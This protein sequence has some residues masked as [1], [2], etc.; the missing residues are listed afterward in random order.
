MER[1][2][3]QVEQKAFEAGINPRLHPQ[4]KKMEPRLPADKTLD[5][6]ACEYNAE[7]F[8]GYI[9]TQDVVGSSPFRTH[10]DYFGF[11]VGDAVIAVARIALEAER[12][13]PGC[14][15]IQSL[16][17]MNAQG[18][19]LGI[20]GADNAW[21]QMYRAPGTRLQTEMHSRDEL[22]RFVLEHHGRNGVLVVFNIGWLV[23]AIHSRP[24]IPRCLFGSGTY[25]SAVRDVI[26]NDARDFNGFF[27]VPRRESYHRRWPAVLYK[28]D[29]SIDFY[30]SESDFVLLEVYYTA[31]IWNAI[32]YQIVADRQR[33][34]A[35]LLKNAYIIGFG[36]AINVKKVQLL[37]PRRNYF[38]KFIG[39]GP[40]D[41]VVSKGLAVKDFK[42]LFMLAADEIQCEM[43][44]DEADVVKVLQQCF[45]LG[46]TFVVMQNAANFPKPDPEV[47][48]LRSAVAT[49]IELAAPHLALAN[50]EMA[51]DW[52]NHHGMRTP[53]ELRS[54]QKRSIAIRRPGP[55]KLLY[56]SFIDLAY[57]PDWM[58]STLGPLDTML[59]LEPED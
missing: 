7:A 35:V 33:P 30:H 14:P 48:K 49:N 51:V 22:R 18:R 17:L 3:N 38:R 42:Q 5:I 19:V 59:I 40:T 6:A 12:G 29:Q 25:I 28:P 20:R 50:F 37:K 34:E 41:E 2:V 24:S 32:G 47:H 56:G 55:E 4:L 45:D 9:R 1:F 44:M 31:A 8:R 23:T 57:E 27:D 15:S 16:V 36:V 43:E 21:Q 26:G 46:K 13:H 58:A 53:S 39:P 54:A 11:T 52:I 10:K